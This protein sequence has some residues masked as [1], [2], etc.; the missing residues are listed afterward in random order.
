MTARL[1][2]SFVIGAS[3][4]ASAALVGPKAGLLLVDAR[5]WV[6]LAAVRGGFDPAKM[7][8]MMK[9]RNE[10]ELKKVKASPAQSKK[11]LAYM[12]H[13]MRARMAY[14]K[15]N[16]GMDRKSMKPVADK[17]RAEQTAFLKKTLSA[18]QFTQWEADMKAMRG[19]G[20]G[21][22]GGP[23]GRPGGPSAR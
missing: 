6:D 23:G 3:L 20:R 7:A 21:G 11:V 2:F 14:M 1:V 17:W 9:K 13:M 18:K 15:A 22:P 5:E 10:D 12:E 19:R 4:L 8:A 16:P